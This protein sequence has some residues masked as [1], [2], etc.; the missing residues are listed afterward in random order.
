MRSQS[1]QQQYATYVNAA[2]ASKGNTA[3][4]GM[5][6]GVGVPGLT[7]TETKEIITTIMS[8]IVYSH[9]GKAINLVSFQSN[10]NDIYKRNGLKQINFPTPPMTDIVLQSCREVFLGTQETSTEDKTDGQ[11]TNNA[12]NKQTDKDELALRMVD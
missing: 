8:A 6:T 10:M 3:G 9:Y 4:R 1:N 5:G 12:S 11:T 7:K 2:T